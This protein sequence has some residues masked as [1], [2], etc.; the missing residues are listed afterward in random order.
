LELVSPADVRRHNVIPAF[1]HLNDPRTAGEK[2]RP[3]RSAEFRHPELFTPDQHVPVLFADR[4]IAGPNF[5]RYSG[6]TGVF[7]GIAQPL[8]LFV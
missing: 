5:F 3:E 8:Y 2:N 1:L 6:R 7:H 4:P